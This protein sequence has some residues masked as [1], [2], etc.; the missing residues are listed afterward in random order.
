[1]KASEV[2]QETVRLQGIAL[3][4]SENDVDLIID[5]PCPLEWGIGRLPL[6]DPESCIRLT[7]LPSLSR[8]GSGKLWP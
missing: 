2:K 4:Q 5:S 3:A 6:Q 8:C 7:P 1:L